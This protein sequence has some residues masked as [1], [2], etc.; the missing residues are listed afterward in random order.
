[1]SRQQG[2]FI[3]ISFAAAVLTAGLVLYGLARTDASAIRADANLPFVD[4]SIDPGSLT[5]TVIK[6]MPK[7]RVGGWALLYDM[8]IIERRSA[9]AQLF[10]RKQLFRRDADV[11][12]K[13]I[14]LPTA[15]MAGQLVV[16]HLLQLSG[17]L[18]PGHYILVVTIDCYSVDDETGFVT[19]A[20]PPAKSD[21][22]CFTV[23]RMAI[24]T[25]QLTLIKLRAEPCVDARPQ[26]AANG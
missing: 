26:G 3:A 17:P 25:P 8:R 12:V 21:P 14:G 13:D 22:R 5:E 16:N 11:P 19:V 1:M 20:A 6:D 15:P 2:L 18:T 23:P 9:C 10:V 24:P 7:G 4:I